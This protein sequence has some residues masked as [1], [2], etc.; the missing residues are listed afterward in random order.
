MNT[1]EFRKIVLYLLLGTIVLF[2]TPIVKAAV[3]LNATDF[4]G[5]NISASELARISLGGL[6]VFGDWINGTNFNV[7]NQLCLGGICKTTW[8]SSW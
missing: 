4:I 3:V 2:L 1:R 8:P 5:F 7:A 6:V